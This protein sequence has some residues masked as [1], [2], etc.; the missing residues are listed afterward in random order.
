[1][2]PLVKRQN[3]LEEI[4]RRNMDEVSRRT[5]Q[6]ELDKIMKRQGV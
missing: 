2:L 6:R 1:L 3:E 4:I 5:A